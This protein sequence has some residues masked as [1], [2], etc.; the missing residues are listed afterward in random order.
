MAIWKGIAR[1][2]PRY[3]IYHIVA[4]LIILVAVG[5]RLLLLALGWPP[6]DS[7]E[8]TVG[9]MGM[10]IAFRGEFPIFFYGQGYMGAFEAYL[11]AIMFL[12]FGV[13]TFTLSLGL[14]LVYAGFLIAMYF[15][16]RLLYS[17]GLA[18]FVLLLLSLG[19]NP[20]LSRE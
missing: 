6:L 2:Y 12:L 5:V 17:N 13:S 1:P 19:S 11:A 15:L 16:V 10:H 20:M 3:N 7:D 8:G 14:V 9:L 4:L 18:L